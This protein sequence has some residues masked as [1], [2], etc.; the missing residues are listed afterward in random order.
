MYGVGFLRGL[1][2]DERLVY[3]GKE[4]FFFLFF[5]ILIDFLKEIGLLDLV[6]LGRVEVFELEDFFILL[7]LVLF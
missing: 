6:F 3:F 1:L 5:L 2:W 7:L 4:L